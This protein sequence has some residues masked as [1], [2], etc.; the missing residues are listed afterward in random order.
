VLSGSH[1]R[2]FVHS[3]LFAHRNRLAEPATGRAVAA[4]FAVSAGV[5]NALGLSPGEVELLT[6]LASGKSNPQ[7]AL[8]LGRSPNTVRNGISRLLS[9]L[10]APSRTAAVGTALRLGLL[11]PLA[12]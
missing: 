7:I 2:Q 10:A 3:F 5:A 9:K 6:Q 4:S 12:G 1:K 8:A 11:Q